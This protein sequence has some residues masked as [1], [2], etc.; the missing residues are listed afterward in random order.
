[1]FLGWADVTTGS[2][3]V[4]AVSFVIALF[5]VVAIELDDPKRS[6]WFKER[7]PAEWLTIDVDAFMKAKR[8]SEEK[9]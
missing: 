8:A 9:R 2:Y 4:F 1:M 6:I 7:I 3:A 5:F